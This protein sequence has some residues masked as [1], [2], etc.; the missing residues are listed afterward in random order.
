MGL[1]G[2]LATMR[3]GMAVAFI[4][5]VDAAYRMCDTLLDLEAVLSYYD[6]GGRLCKSVYCAPARRAMQRVHLQIC[7]LRACMSRLTTFRPKKGPHPV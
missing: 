4:T 2:A 7:L 1:S 5:Q 3:H 6:R